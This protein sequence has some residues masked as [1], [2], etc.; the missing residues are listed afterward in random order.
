M[1]KNNNVI[2]NYLSDKKRFADMIN[3]ELYGGMQVIKPDK[4]TEISGTSYVA[5]GKKNGSASRNRRER[6]QDLS[7]RYVDGAIYRI[8]LTEAQDKVSY[9]LPFRDLDYMAASY[10]RQYEEIKREHDRNEDYGSMAE[11]FSGFNKSDRLYP[12]Y[13]LWVYYGEKRWDGPRTLKDMMNFGD[14]HDGFSRVFKDLEPHL[15]C[16]NEMTD[17]GRYITEVRALFDLLRHRL[18]KAGLMALVNEDERY[19]RL[20][21]ETYETAAV[22]M[23]APVLLKKRSEYAD[24]EGR[25]YD[26]CKALR[27]W[28]ADIR[29]ES[30]EEIEQKEAEIEQKEAEIE[31]L[32]KENALLR[33]KLEA[34]GLS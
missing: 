16:I 34:A 14:D 21:E 29:K 23:N 5:V 18:D 9:T 17:T 7:M 24:N 28:E 22:L 30:A 32:E 1:G 20:D 31:D 4:L 10:R 27:D 11:K 19:N 26:M 8:F 12:A 15:L 13:L 6:R 33:A 25:A 3:A 2:I